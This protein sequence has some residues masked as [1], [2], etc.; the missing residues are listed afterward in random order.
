MEQ[1]EYL[2]EINDGISDMY[3]MT[4]EM[5]GDLLSFLKEQKPELAQ[6]LCKKGRAVVAREEE[7]IDSCVEAL[8]RH[9]PFAGDLRAVTSAMRVSYDLARVSRY[10]TNIVQVLTDVDSGTACFPEVMQLLELGWEMIRD[11]VDSYLSRDPL[12]AESVMARDNLVDSGY[13]QTLFRC[14]EANEGAGCALLNGL[15]ARIIERMADHGCYISAETI[16]M[17]T[18]NRVGVRAPKCPPSKTSEPTQ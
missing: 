18:G 1:A 16:Y 4:S 5:Y 7:I 2:K 3:R 14:K 13:R 12:K 10:L 8:I 17:V 15:M 11:S 6:A 9:Q